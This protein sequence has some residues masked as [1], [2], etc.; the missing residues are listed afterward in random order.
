MIILIIVGIVFSLFIGFI[1]GYNY[2]NDENDILRTEKRNLEFRLMVK[3]EALRKM[4]QQIVDIM[5]KEDS[6]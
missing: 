4:M 6:K 1:F 5:K 2:Q 3:D